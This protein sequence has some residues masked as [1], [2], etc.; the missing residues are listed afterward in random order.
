MSVAVIASER[1]SNPSARNSAASNGSGGRQRRAEPVTDRVRRDGKFF[2][3]GDEK[4]FV[5][6]VTYGPFAPNREGLLLPDRA[7]VRRDFEQMRELGANCLRIYHVP[8]RW[9]LDLAQEL[10]LKIFL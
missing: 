3:V 9:F 7:Q 10:G 1:K 5:K 4:F 8:P 2:R 6:G